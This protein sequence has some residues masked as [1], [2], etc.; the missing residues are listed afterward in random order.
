MSF[1]ERGKKPGL[2]VFGAPAARPGMLMPREGGNQGGGEGGR[3]GGREG[4]VRREGWHDVIQG[5]GKETR[6]VRVGGTGSQARNLN[7]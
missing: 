4:E 5:E 6:V 7:A 3:E 1:R 2:W